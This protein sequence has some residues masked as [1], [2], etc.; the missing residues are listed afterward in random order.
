MAFADYLG[1]RGWNLDTQTGIVT[2]GEDLQFNVQ[3]LGT[4]SEVDNSWLWAW[5]NESSGLPESVIATSL[6]MKADGDGSASTLTINGGTINLADNIK[7]NDT[8]ENDQ[9][10]MNGGTLNVT[11]E[12]ANLE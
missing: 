9:I 5:A 1:D 3:I 7:F 2:F 4:H 6:E 12:I 8:A 10:I 11:D